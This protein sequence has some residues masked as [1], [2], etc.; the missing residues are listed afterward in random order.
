MIQI[1]ICDKFIVYKIILRIWSIYT[2]INMY[3]NEF[4]IIVDAGHPSITSDFKTYT[5]FK[6]YLYLEWLSKK[7][8]HLTSIIFVVTNNY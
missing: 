3:K 5:D 8:F 2:I 6:N 1:I 7:M 4:E